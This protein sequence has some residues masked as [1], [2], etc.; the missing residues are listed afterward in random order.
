ME[1]SLPNVILLGIWCGVHDQAL[2][3]SLTHL[4]AML[5]L[6][7]LTTDPWACNI[8]HFSVRNPRQI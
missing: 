3:H 7:A 8:N 2:A 5:H 6:Y 4:L 1:Y